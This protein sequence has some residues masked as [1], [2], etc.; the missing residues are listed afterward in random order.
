LPGLVDNG[1]R[2]AEP[3]RLVWQGERDPAV[4]TAGLNPNSALIVRALLEKIAGGT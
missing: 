3:I 4:L 2:I 1:W